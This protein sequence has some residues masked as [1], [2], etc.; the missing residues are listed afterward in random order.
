M[1]V[2]WTYDV[3]DD[4][5]GEAEWRLRILLA[6]ETSGCTLCGVPVDAVPFVYWVTQDDEILVFHD[7]CAQRMATHL[8]SDGL[9]AEKGPPR[10][11]S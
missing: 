4:H 6:A 7:L 8:A 2:V 9:A 10:V 5:D 3:P 11:A 1:A